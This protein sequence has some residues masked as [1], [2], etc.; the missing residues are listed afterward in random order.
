MGYRARRRILPFA[1]CATLVALGIAAA[2]GPAKHAPYAST[3][4]SVPSR[5]HDAGPDGNLLHI[6]PPPLPGV[7]APG[8]CGRTIVPIVVDRPNLYFILD[9]S[10]SMSLP[11]R[12]LESHGVIP[13]RIDAARDAIH[14]LL[15]LIGHRVS[16]GA[17]IFPSFPTLKDPVCP[18]GGEVFE[19]ETGDDA[20]YAAAG[21][22]GPVLTALRK[23][24]D[25][26]KP[27]GLTPT[28]ISIENVKS[29]LLALNGRTYAIL[30]TD[31]APNCGAFP[32]CGAA[33]CTLNIEGECPENPG[34]SCC[35]PANGN[36]DGTWCLDSDATV[37][38]I[39]DLQINGIRTFVVGMPGTETYTSV[40]DAFATAGGTAQPTEPYF[41][42]VESTKD[43][44]ET[45][46]KIGLS[47]AIS[48]SIPLVA[49]PPDPAN[50]NVYFDQAVVPL[51]DANGWKWTDDGTIEVVGDSCA[52]L[53]SGSVIEVQVV[54]GC[55]SVTR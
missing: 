26:R 35:D 6:P 49:P 8:I 25:A 54:A 9:A 53:Q 7:D 27:D 41:Y 17:A 29:N 15:M 12:D 48:C 2:C 13:S 21:R 16:Y 24:L 38:A 1:C 39:S 52:K 34:V 28:A 33:T 11:M 42:P 19:T 14:D 23:T 30:L 51:D 36:Y 50:V 4:P 3:T 47:I 44:A 55:P 37:N 18:P 40:L 5:V 43:L 46:T 45:L 32:R 31:G 22:E 10:G 20:R